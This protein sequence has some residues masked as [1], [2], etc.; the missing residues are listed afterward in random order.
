MEFMADMV[1]HS[2]GSVPFSLFRYRELKV[3]GDKQE[4]WT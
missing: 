3:V 4:S 1:L 2:E